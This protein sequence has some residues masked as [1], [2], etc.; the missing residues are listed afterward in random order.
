MRELLMCGAIAATLLADARGPFT[1][2]IPL[3]GLTPAHQEAADELLTSEG[4]A[5]GG[6][7]QVRAGHGVLS[8]ATGAESDRFLLHLSDV[9]S[10]VERLGFEIEPGD[11]VLKPQMMALAVSAHEE[12][13]VER[14][15]P[16][17][18]S[19]RAVLAAGE[20]TLVVIELEEEE[21]Y[22]A[23]AGALQGLGVRVDDL[24]W[25]HW[26]YGWRLEERG[27]PTEV[28]GARHPG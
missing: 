5:W 12:L 6:V 15:E 18:P 24:V 16:V 10:V 25:G 8:L 3:R 17:L 22:S 13:T 19:V 11:W 9:R 27:E 2:E 26:E 4:W 21:P 14:I 7:F 23:I 20:E 28:F 1:I